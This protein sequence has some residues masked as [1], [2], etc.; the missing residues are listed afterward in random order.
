M[1]FPWLKDVLTTNGPFLS[2]YLDTTRTDP[3]LA[4]EIDAR[5]AHLKAEATRAGAPKGMLDDIEDL[6]RQ[7]S[8]MGGRHGQAFIATKDRLQIERVIPLPPRQD[9]AAWSDHP[10]LLPIMRIAAKAVSYIIVEVDRY[11]ADFKL[12][13]PEDPHLIGSK[14]GLGDDSVVEGGHD[15]VHKP[16][17]GWR[18]HK[19]EARVEDSWE[20]NA[21]A[22]AARLD[23]L[24]SRYRP[25]MVLLSG[26]IRAE[27]LLKEAVNQ[28]TKT[29]IVCVPGGSRGDN[30]DKPS[31]AAAVATAVDQFVERKGQELVGKLKEEQARDG[32]V[33][34]GA[35]ETQEALKRGQVE[36][37]VLVEGE[38]PDSIEELLRTAILTD[39]DIRTIQPGQVR[40]PEGI[41]GLLR[42]KDGATPSN[43]I[44]SL[45]GDPARESASRESA[46]R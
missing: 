14:D 4:A 36:T 5:W 38:E 15:E 9:V 34:S 16:R 29:R 11:G 45:N 39:A 19:F 13:A 8:G 44:A 43:S 26:D 41:G 35:Q 46:N 12:R 22:V 21:D 20:R 1:K 10:Q 25:D 17:S 33:V 32:D 40:L 24:V 31:F 23:K 6:V 27:N 7:P 30:G 3:A 42:W 28:D 18:G 37:L 2:I